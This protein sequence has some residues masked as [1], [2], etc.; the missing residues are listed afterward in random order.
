M[1]P[2]S[3][4][5]GNMQS[6]HYVSK[7]PL[8]W[9][10]KLSIV[11]ILLC[12]SLARA[13]YFEEHQLSCSA[14]N[15]SYGWERLNYY[16]VLGFSDSLQAHEGLDSK[17]IRSAYRRQAQ[18]WHPDKVKPNA[19]LPIEEINGRFAQISQAY[20]TLTDPHKRQA[21][22]QFLKDCEYNKR[23]Q[24]PRRPPSHGS[25]RSDSTSSYYDQ[26]QQRRQ[27]YQNHNQH[28]N[29]NRPRHQSK[30][31]SVRQERD[32]FYDPLTGA[33]IMR[34]T[35]YE[36]YGRANY[37]CIKIQDY[38]I[39]SMDSWGNTYY[40]PLYPRPRVVEE[41][42]IHHQTGHPYNGHSNQQ[43]PNS[44]Y[45]EKLFQSGPSA[46]EDGDVVT[47]GTML[48]SENQ[49]YRARVDNCRLVIETRQKS[50]HNDPTPQVEIEVLWKSN[51]EMPLY[52]G[53]AD[54]FLAFDGGG[55]IL[56]VDSPQ[57][58]TGEILWLSGVPDYYGEDA[59][60][61]FSDHT[62]RAKL[63]DDGKLVVYRKA[64]TSNFDEPICVWATG[65]LGCVRT[66]SRLLHMVRV[67][68]DRLGPTLQH[69][70]N[71]LSDSDS[72]NPFQNQQKGEQVHEEEDK[73][74]IL[75]DF[76]GAT[77]R[78]F[79]EKLGPTFKS[80][81]GLGPNYD[82]FNPFHNAQ[83]AQEFHWE[84][85]EASYFSALLGAAKR[86][87]KDFNRAR[88]DVEASLE[89]RTLQWVQRSMSMWHEYR[90]AW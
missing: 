51:N 75:S 48:V 57:F 20:Q 61:L 47:S 83:K 80:L 12:S 52:G 5:H 4:Q 60:F 86:A 31:T 27:S 87:F 40:Q 59:S 30:P 34:E 41:G 10:W 70:F 42:P 13:Q 81:F 90:P 37:Y 35:I 23:R 14:D 28:S 46:L 3:P 18:S 54:C 58:P 88:R 19:T 71:F 49:R 1:F 29:N 55:L 44:R 56:A 53:K 66:V 68:R 50:A 17:S 21:Y 79:E 85:D 16:E 15:V 25:D 84:D 78:V 6:H 24:R 76:L 62:Y 7:M 11:Y 64:P 73:V 33:P 43:E 26:H 63:E 77:K 38:L 65:P 36:E 82:P 45:E 69:L 32:M 74:S 39:Q 9:T 8:G 2:W 72:N 67:G 22:D 89:K